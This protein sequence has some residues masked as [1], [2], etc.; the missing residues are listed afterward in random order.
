[1]RRTAAKSNTTLGAFDGSEEYFLIPVTFRGYPANL[2]WK[3]VANTPAAQTD[4]AAE[5]AQY[6][7]QEFL[8]SL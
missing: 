3:G 5:T 2:L 6:G 8:R 4:A 7:S 1:M